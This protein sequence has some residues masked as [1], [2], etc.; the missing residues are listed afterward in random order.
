ML[1]HF[2]YSSVSLFLFVVLVGAVWHLVEE[3]KK[4]EDE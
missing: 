1:D 2:S 4:E 3:W